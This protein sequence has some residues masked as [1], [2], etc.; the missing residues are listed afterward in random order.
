MHVQGHSTR[1]AP[2]KETEGL[3]PNLVMGENAPDGAFCCTCANGKQVFSMCVCKT[4][5]ATRRADHNIRDHKYW[6]VW[7]M[8][9]LYLLTRS[10]E[11]CTMDGMLKTTLKFIC[12]V[13]VLWRLTLVLLN[14]WLLVF[15]ACL[16]EI[17]VF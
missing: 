2:L 12:R 6:K 11:D 10:H 17:D 14:I 4:P 8:G 9:I 5:I 1:R 15:D 3:S 13:K 7:A 16:S